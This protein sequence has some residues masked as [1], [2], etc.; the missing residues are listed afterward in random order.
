MLEHPRDRDSECSCVS[1]AHEQTV[2]APADSIRDDGRLP[3]WIEDLAYAAAVR[4]ND[5]GPHRKRLDD[6]LSERLGNGRSMDEQAEPTE[7]RRG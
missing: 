4:R 2:C 6:H 3:S 7:L 1:G 5:R